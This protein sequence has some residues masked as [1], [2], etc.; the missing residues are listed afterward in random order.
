VEGVMRKSFSDLVGR[1]RVE[2][3]FGMYGEEG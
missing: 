1:R 3:V 2:K